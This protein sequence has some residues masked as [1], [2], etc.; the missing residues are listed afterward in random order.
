MTIAYEIA[1][2]DY[3]E[4]NL[5]HIQNSPSQK[6]LYNMMR[7]LLPVPFVPVVYFTGTLVLHQPSILWMIV[8]I[9]YYAWWLYFY[10]KQHKKTIKKQTI[11]L[12]D[13]GDNTSFFAKKSLDIV[14]D[15]LIFMEENAT[16]TLS[17]DKIKSIKE[18]D[19]MFVLYLSAVSAHI[20]PKQYLSD[21]DMNDIR[22]IL[23]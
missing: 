16:S 19:D 3:I 20:I 6:K 23:D 10:P 8:A 4:F 22:A 7:F 5:Y 9:L 12:L 18:Y 13:E 15:N 21:Q 14:D 1:E 11:K 2:E 17:K